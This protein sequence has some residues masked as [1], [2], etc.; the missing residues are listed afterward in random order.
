M[1]L[2]SADP[3]KTFSIGFA[4]SAFNELDHAKAVADRY[5]TDH[6]TLMVRP[7]SIELISTL[8][9]H[10]DEPFGDSSAI[11]TYLVSRFR[12]RAREGGADGRRRGRNV[13]RLL[14]LL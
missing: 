2:Q 8:V 9:Q 11:P 6:H 7:D 1:A 5:K 14:Q 10:L 4:E 12:A 13:R 3:V